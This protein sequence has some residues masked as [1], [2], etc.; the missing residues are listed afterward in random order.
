VFRGEGPVSGLYSLPLTYINAALPR[1]GQINSVN[2]SSARCSNTAESNSQLILNREPFG[3]GRL[4]REWGTLRAMV[5]CYC[6]DLHRTPGKEL[7]LDCQALLSY[8]TVRLERCRF[9]ETKPT[10]AKCPVHCYA[11][12]RREQVKTVMRYAGPRMLWRHPVLSLFH[13][14]DTFRRAPELC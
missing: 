5:L 3:S 1:T 7:C 8:A 10:C 2:A 4:K 13:W 11:A 14:L 6:H 9:G 12:N